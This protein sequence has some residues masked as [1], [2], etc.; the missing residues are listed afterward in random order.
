[1]LNT[2]TNFLP[3]T[4]SSVPAMLGLWVQRKGFESPTFLPD[5]AIIVLQD[6][7]PLIP[8]GKSTWWAGIR[9]GRFPNGIKL[10]HNTT[11]WRVSDIRQLLE[12]LS[13]NGE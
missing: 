6:I 1:M 9:S 8:Y 2:G 12:Q 3:E 13:N 10:G 11:G 5:Q 4:Q 7:L